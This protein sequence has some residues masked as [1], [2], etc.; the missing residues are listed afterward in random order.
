MISLDREKKRS[1]EPKR[2]QKK[3]TALE[4]KLKRRKKDLI[5]ERATLL[6]KLMPLHWRK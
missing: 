3:V 1:D 2:A 6:P 4:G 5:P